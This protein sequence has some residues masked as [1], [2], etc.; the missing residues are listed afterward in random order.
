MDL[1]AALVVSASVFSL[2]LIV[3]VHRAAEAYEAKYRTK[4]GWLADS[5]SEAK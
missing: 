4:Y 5:S 3:C 1:S 2:A